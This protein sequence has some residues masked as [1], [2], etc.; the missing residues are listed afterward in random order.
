[1]LLRHAQALAAMTKLIS[2]NDPDQLQAFRD[3]YDA[4]YNDGY[5]EGGEDASTEI[6]ALRLKLAKDSLD[7]MIQSNKWNEAYYT[8]RTALR[9]IAGGH[10]E[11]DASSIV[12][13]H[14]ALARAALDTDKSRV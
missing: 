5:A 4:G 9:V 10:I 12:E 14:I 3:G 7:A 8:F 6:D 1:M 13:K 11:G 2:V